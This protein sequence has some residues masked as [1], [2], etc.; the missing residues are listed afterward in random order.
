LEELL[1]SDSGMNKVM[2]DVIRVLYLCMGAL[3]LPELLD[4]YKVFTKALDDVPANDEVVMEAIDELSR[5]GIVNVR[6]GIRATFT[7]EGEKTFLISLREE[8]I[9]VDVLRNDERIRKYRDLWSSYL[10]GSNSR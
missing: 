4:E 10:K 7:P 2:G 5:L 3:W 9:K 6:E 1:K 8:S